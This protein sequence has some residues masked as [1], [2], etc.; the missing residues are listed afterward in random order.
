MATP[1]IRADGLA[2]LTCYFSKICDG[3]LVT[4]KC[5][6]HLLALYARF[7]TEAPSLLDPALIKIDEVGHADD[8]AD[9][10]SAPHIGQ[11]LS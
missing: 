10:I 7:P 9:A 5:F 11:R 3:I 1:T 2:A 8:F 6:L 4:T